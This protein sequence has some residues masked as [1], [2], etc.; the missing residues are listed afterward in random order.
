MFVFFQLLRTTLNY[1]A[2]RVEFNSLLMCPCYTLSVSTLTRKMFKCP[3]LISYFT[4]NERW[5]FYGIIFSSFPHWRTKRRLVLLF[6][7]LGQLCIATAKEMGSE[8]GL[9]FTSENA[10]HASS[11]PKVFYKQKGNNQNTF[12]YWEKYT[13]YFC[14][15]SIFK[16]FYWDRNQCK[17]Q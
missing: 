6:S 9:S 8:F 10:F 1:V 16:F 17:I 4:D 7:S 2:F 15:F 11:W 12:S 3:S 14:F 13:K 5:V